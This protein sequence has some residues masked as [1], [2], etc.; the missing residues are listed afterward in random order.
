VT[1]PDAGGFEYTD[2]SVIARVSVDVPDTA[3][4]DILK[5]SEA[6]G[7]MRAQL[8][9]V[10]DA[11]QN[12]VGFLSQ[13]P[14]T[15]TSV[16]DAIKDQITLLER[17]S[18]L[19][20]GGSF[21]GPSGAYAGGGGAGAP[22]YSTAA[23][24]GYGQGPWGQNTP[25]MG[26]GAMV[27]AMNGM[28]EGQASQQVERIA[29]ENPGLAQNMESVREGGGGGLSG[30]GAIAVGAAA[31]AIARK[32]GNPQKTSGARDST[33]DPDPAKG[34]VPE[35][36]AD[37]NTPGDPNPM[38]SDEVKKQTLIAQV[39]DEFKTGGKAGRAGR[40]GDLIAD[41]AGRA[42]L[43]G[44]IAG[45]RSGVPGGGGSDTDPSGTKGGLSGMLG[46][47]PVV[48]DLLSGIVG[49]PAGKAVGAVGLGAYAFNKVQ[50][51]GEKITDFQQLGS[52][53][54][55][56][57]M[58]GMK[59]EAQARMMALNP[60]ITTQQARQ[61]MQMAL[62][63]GFRGDN[64]DNVNDFMI[65]NFKEMGISMG[66]SMDLMKS[67]IRGLSETDDQ[68]GVKKNLDQTLNTMK[69]MSKEGGLSFPERVNQMQEMSSELSA[70]GF[71]P[72]AI[73]R[74]VLGTQEG[75]GDSMA[76][77]GSA[78]RITAQTTGSS[79]L[80]TM[81]AQK[82]GI[83]GMLPNALPAAME[84]AGLDP[85]EIRDQA[86][87]QVA[88]YVSGYSDPLNRIGAFQM[89]MGQYGVELDWPEAEAL[90][91]KVAG[92][93]ELPSQQANRKVARQG[94]T[95][96]AGGSMAGR[97]VERTTSSNPADSD[98]TK[99]HPYYS[100]SE[101]AAGVSDNFD[102]AGRGTNFSGTGR[103]PVP[104]PSTPQPG[105]VINSHGTVSGEVRIVVDQQGRVT[106]PQVIQLSGQQK[107]AN[108]GHS[109]AQLNN[110]PPGD[111]SYN[112]SYNAFATPS[113][114]G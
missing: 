19:Q 26:L 11:Q 34:G 104:P 58:T 54:G 41:A 28:N 76:L 63:E 51:I 91:N 87:A 16:N 35:S 78:G 68:S 108:A 23:P 98:W 36:S 24:A 13:M 111:P 3:L 60:F 79:M 5:L 66:Q 97:G 1:T 47:I 14:E 67:H 80:M 49:S 33:A 7:N 4:T 42:V 21:T 64:Y 74:A 18:Y 83:T 72:E 77:R 45:G 75:L 29:A 48:G 110:A 96:T 2:D 39:L 82:M 86:A 8:E 22:G 20:S 37:P 95:Q 90:Y 85:D 73:N 88:G 46:K 52:V 40:I 43:G 81:A 12:W 71:G 38:A 106:A 9:Q 65:Q 15:I 105:Q 17:Q 61:A 56:D 44:G 25:G 103:P 50:D 102:A 10:A 70:Q 31:N 101:N 112:N 107:A 59:Y 55:G 109:S 6:M 93:K 100:P 30:R 62:K 57:Y 53:Q 99:N 27:G 92:G 94:K 69:E 32:F 84:R 114:G 113:G 89:L